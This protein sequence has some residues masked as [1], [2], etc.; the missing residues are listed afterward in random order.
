MGGCIS[1]AEWSA[2][3]RAPNEIAYG[4]GGNQV[5]LAQKLYMLSLPGP[6]MC[7]S[8]PRASSGPRKERKIA[9]VSGCGDAI[10]QWFG[11]D[12]PSDQRSL[13]SASRGIHRMIE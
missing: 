10:L 6:S 7:K 9:K 1:A 12:S 11:C 4:T 3:G 5:D 2:P 8:P 13:L